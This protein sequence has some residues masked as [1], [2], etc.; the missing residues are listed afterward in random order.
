MTDRLAN[1]FKRR[2]TNIQKNSTISDQTTSPLFLGDN[3]KTDQ[4]EPTKSVEFSGHLDFL[5]KDESTDE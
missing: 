3:S 1:M 2:I 4:M 5:D